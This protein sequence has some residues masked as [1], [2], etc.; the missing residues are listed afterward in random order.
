VEGSVRG[1]RARPDQGGL[2]QGDTD[3]TAMAA[4]AVT[5]CHNTIHVIV[6]W[7]TAKLQ[8]YV[9]RKSLSNDSRWQSTAVWN[10]SVALAA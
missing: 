4:I 10:D 7:L 2:A 1:R 9:L 5:C 8:S 6:V 3:L